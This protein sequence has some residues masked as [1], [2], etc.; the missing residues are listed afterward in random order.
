MNQEKKQTK[1]METARPTIS[2]RSVIVTAPD[3]TAFSGWGPKV[4]G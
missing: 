1:K 4:A 2:L 3:T